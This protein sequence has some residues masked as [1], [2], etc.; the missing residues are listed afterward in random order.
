MRFGYWKYLAAG[1]ACAMALTALVSAPAMAA[2]TWPRDP[3]RLVVP[4]PPGGSVDITARLF[5]KSLST[6]L[7]GAS[8]VVEN[9]PGA[10]NNIGDSRV[11][12]AKPDGYTLLFAQ[13]N[14]VL[15][16]I[17]GPKPD[18]DAFKQLAPI[19]IV[20]RVPYII[21]ASPNEPF[22]TIQDFLKAAKA[23]PGK[24]TISSAQLDYYVGL[25]Q[26]K[27]GIK[28][29]HIPYK[30]GAQAM[31]DTS[32]GAI[33][34]IFALSPVVTPY[35]QGGKL[36]AL[37]VT[38]DQRVSILPD[39]PTLKEVGVNYDNTIWFAL[40]APAGTPSEIISKLA[41][42]TKKVAAD[43]EFVAALRRFGSTPE[44]SGPKALLDQMHREVSQGE[45]TAK[46]IPSLVQEDMRKK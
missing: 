25:L 4:F 40:L 5:A 26:I 41:A 6:A 12:Y 2:D 37:A 33:N 35:L 46:L 43:P 10:E 9:R 29:Q 7:S 32:S 34:S 45:N 16:P 44:G 36:K 30:G 22:N 15:N 11:A 14:L 28:L 20:A 19:S 3:I 27:A 1:A 23:A 39:V 8:I 17:F 21:A 31:T 38:A 42:A 13:P 18:F 24:Y